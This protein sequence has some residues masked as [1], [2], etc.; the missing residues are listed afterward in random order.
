MP[1]TLKF[2]DENGVW[3]GVDVIKGEPGY[4]P[5]KGVDYF[6]EADV[7][8]IAETAAGM[9]EVSGGDDSDAYETAADVLLASG[10]IASGAAVD[11]K[12][13]TGVTMRDLQ[14]YRR[15][16]FVWDGASNVGLTNTYLGFDDATFRKQIARFGGG[17]AKFFY[18]WVNSER[19]LLEIYGAGEGNSSLIDAN[20]VV[21]QIPAS[22]GDCC[23]YSGGCA[24]FDLSSIAPDTELRIHITNVSTIDY[25]WYIK[26]LTV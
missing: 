8:E 14:A 13:Y 4:T 21:T 24:L 11:T 10:V 5:V 1:S 19:T 20:V 16:V 6:T 9:V 23:F 3:Q 2:K 17:G 7:Q 26:G 18:K 12:T 25:N 15:F 22:L